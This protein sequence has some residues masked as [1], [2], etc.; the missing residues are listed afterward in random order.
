MVHPAVL[1][2]VVQEGEREQHLPHDVA[3]LVLLDAHQAELALWQ[4]G[5]HLGL[6]TGRNGR[7]WCSRA[8]LLRPRASCAHAVVQDSG[9]AGRERQAESVSELS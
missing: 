9:A 1:Q 6:H 7:K 4:G 2:V 3:R 5:A 8:R